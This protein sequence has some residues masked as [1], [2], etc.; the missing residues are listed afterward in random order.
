MLYSL[1]LQW[2]KLIVSI[3]ETNDDFSIHSKDSNNIDYG[4][5]CEITDFISVSYIGNKLS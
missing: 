1:N 5:L 3:N 2:V 4:N